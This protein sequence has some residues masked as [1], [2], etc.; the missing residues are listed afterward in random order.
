MSRYID[1]DKVVDTLKR[2]RLVYSAEGQQHGA[3]ALV[4]AIRI[5]EDAPGYPRVDVK[6]Q[7]LL[8]ERDVADDGYK[9]YL[10]GSM[11]RE[12]GAYAAQHGYID[13]REETV[14]YE[15]G[16]PCKQSLL[17]R[18]A[19]LLPIRA[20]VQAGRRQLRGE[21]VMTNGDCIRRMTDEELADVMQGQCACC[22]YQLTG[23]TERECK[24][25]AY[26]CL[27]KE[28]VEDA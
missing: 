14:K 8:P 18:A 11:A 26:E 20:E 15:D 12:L 16:R 28:A 21:A 5:I 23:C 22:A 9:E 13:C 25:G 3:A 17:M 1:A 24:D 6:D 10:K 27:R 19:F 4:T 7:Q 2:L